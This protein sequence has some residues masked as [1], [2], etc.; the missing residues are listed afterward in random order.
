MNETGIDEKA[1][2]RLIKR[3]V[4]AGVDSVHADPQIGRMTSHDSSLFDHHAIRESG[5]GR[6]NAGSADEGGE[7]KVE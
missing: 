2:V 6:R 5:G 3:L 7:T 1:F 4:E